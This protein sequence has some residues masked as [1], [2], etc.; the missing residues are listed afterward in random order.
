MAESIEPKQSIG[1][2]AIALLLYVVLFASLG[3]VAFFYDS[4]L[5]MDTITPGEM[6]AVLSNFRENQ[7]ERLARDVGEMRKLLGEM[8]AIRDKWLREARIAQDIG[9]VLADDE[10]AFR[11]DA[12][13][14]AA[15]FA[16][17]QVYDVG[18]S[19]EQDMITVYRE[20]L[21]AR[22]VGLRPGLGYDEAYEA[23]LTPRPRRPELDVAAL[24][25]DVTTTRAGGGLEEFKAE[26][27]RS[28]VETREMQENCKKL[29]A[30]TRKSTTQ[31]GDGLGVD[32]SA[33]D[34]AMLGYRGPELLPD[35]M[36]FTF[37]HDKGNFRALPG[38]RMVAGGRT[39]DWLYVDTWYII[40][41]F[42]GDR[43]RQNLDTRFGPEANV[44]LDDVFAGK[45]DRNVRWEYSKAGWAQSVGPKTAFWIIMPKLVDLY[46][47]YYA[48]TEIS[49]DADRE[50]W[51]ATGTDDY[52]KLW[53]NDKLV[54]KSPKEPKPYNATENIQLAKL[55]QGQNKVLY[56]VE[57]AGGTMGFSLMIRLGM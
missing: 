24:Y 8:K 33:D 16:L 35:E 9:A 29:L 14:D 27:K 19:V 56:R 55:R 46:A 54:W 49:C 45:G 4:S 12:Q 11:R 2:K 52:G 50:V 10:R 23:S 17:H 5:R 44:N 34:L 15:G 40:G 20:F 32:M 28:T 18:R 26:I 53:I 22:M 7:T 30:F 48:F 1:R 25:R 21:A 3:Y 39:S 41:P 37:E 51:I 31:T 36:D 42:A 38:R 43:R 47:I 13:T 57:N 6:R